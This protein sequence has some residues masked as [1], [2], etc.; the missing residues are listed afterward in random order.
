MSEPD[1]RAPEAHAWAQLIAGGGR[2]LGTLGRCELP[3]IFHPGADAETVNAD[4]EEVSRNK[5]ELFEVRIPM[6]HTITL[7]ALA[8]KRPVQFFRPSRM[9]ERTVRQQEM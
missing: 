2:W 8:T 7:L 5:A 3:G 1:W 4:T 9:V 6:K